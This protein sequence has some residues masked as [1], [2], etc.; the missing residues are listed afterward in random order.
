[1]VRSTSYKNKILDALVNHVA[2][3]ITTPYISLH[4]S[5]PGGTGA[6]ECAGGSYA[7]Q[8]ASFG[9][10]NLGSA[11]NDVEIS[12]TGMPACTVSHVGIWDALA[13]SF[14]WGGA[15][16]ASKVVNA[17]DT[18]KFTVGNLTVSDTDA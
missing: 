13:G 18:F 17:G 8:P 4:T 15:L 3:D 2:L 10:A 1:M 5:D 16:S 6:N 7:R 9:P 14:V 11:S 12:F